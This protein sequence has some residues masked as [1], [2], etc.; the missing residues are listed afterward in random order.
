MIHTHAT[1]QYSPLTETLKLAKLINIGITIGKDNRYFKIASPGWCTTTTWVDAVDPCS[2][3]T[4]MDC[5]AY[6]PIM[7]VP[8]WDTHTQS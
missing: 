5:D 6:G 7:Q 1:K 2:K 4:W 8:Q 3:P